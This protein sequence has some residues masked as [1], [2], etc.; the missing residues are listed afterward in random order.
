MKKKIKKSLVAACYLI[1]GTSQDKPT[2]NAHAYY[3]F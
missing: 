3:E 2:V 1:Q